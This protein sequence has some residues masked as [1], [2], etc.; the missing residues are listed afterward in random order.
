MLLRP[1]GVPG[2]VVLTVN[3]HQYKQEYLRLIHTTQHVS[4][5]DLSVIVY[6]VLI[7]LY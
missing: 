3:V 6:S 1:G 4:I 7:V 2:S 5:R